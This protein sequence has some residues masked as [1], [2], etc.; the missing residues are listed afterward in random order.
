MTIAMIKL[1]RKNMEIQ[2][3]NQTLKKIKEENYAILHIN[4]NNLE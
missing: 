4:I 2:N 1:K 3:L